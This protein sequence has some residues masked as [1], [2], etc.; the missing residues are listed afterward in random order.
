MKDDGHYTDAEIFAFRKQ[1]R[2]GNA[3]AMREAHKR[4]IHDWIADDLSVAQKMMMRPEHVNKLLDRL[5]PAS[6]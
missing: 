4:A 2:E 3:A 1:L 6:A 5:C